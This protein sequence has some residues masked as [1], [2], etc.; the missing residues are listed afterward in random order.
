MALTATSIS[1]A[2]TAGGT[3]VTLTS[4]TGIANKQKLVVDGES[5]RVTDISLAPTVQVVRGT[6]GTAAVAHSALAP[7]VFGSTIDF[8]TQNVGAPGAGNSSSAVASYSVNGAITVP[9]V[10]TTV[11]FTKAGVAS[12]TPADPSADQQNTVV[13]EALTAQA[14]TVTNTTGFNSGGTA[15]DVA[16]FGGAIGDGFAIKAQSGKWN[17]LWTKNVTLG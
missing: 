14:N 2:L 9:V 13:F 4:S 1:A 10:D 5:M 6:G 15:S 16:T 3:Q 11:Y 7:A 8:V 17:V 12:M